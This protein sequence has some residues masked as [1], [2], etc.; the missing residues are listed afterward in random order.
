M[1]NSIHKNWTLYDITHKGNLLSWISSN[2]LLSSQLKLTQ[3]QMIYFAQ[4]HK[5]PIKN[6]WPGV[7]KWMLLMPS[8]IINNFKT[9]KVLAVNMIRTDSI[10]I[11]HSRSRQS[12]ISSLKVRDIT[13]SRIEGNLVPFIKKLRNAK[14]IKFKTFY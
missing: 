1:P 5:N 2:Q 11:S 8:Y 13:F 9:C 7:L 3:Y 4:L 12:N 14:Q 10:D 6:K